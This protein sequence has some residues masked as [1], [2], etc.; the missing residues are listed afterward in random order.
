MVV[1][2]KEDRILIIKLYKLKS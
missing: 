1:F 2:S